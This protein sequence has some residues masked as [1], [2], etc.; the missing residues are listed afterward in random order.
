MHHRKFHDIVSAI[1]ESEGGRLD[2]SESSYIAQC[3]NPENGYKEIERVAQKLINDR[4]YNAALPC[5]KLGSYQV[6]YRC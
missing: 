2:A 5:G 6:L 3:G 1:V 4:H